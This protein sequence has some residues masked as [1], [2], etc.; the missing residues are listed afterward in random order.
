LAEI[1]GLQKAIFEM[2]GDIFNSYLEKNLFPSI[3]VSPAAAQEYIRALQQLDIKQFKKYFQVSHA[4]R[5]SDFRHSQ[6]NDF[7]R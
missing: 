3:G 7:W 1:A 2:K 5:D 6:A 4:S